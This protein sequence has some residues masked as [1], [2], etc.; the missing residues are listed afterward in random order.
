LL[1]SLE[2]AKNH[3]KAT[4]WKYDVTMIQAAASSPLAGDIRLDSMN[5]IFII[6]AH[7]PV[8]EKQSD[9]N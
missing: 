8:P 9:Q 5:P 4:G 2:A 6:S 3:F 7:K 1:S